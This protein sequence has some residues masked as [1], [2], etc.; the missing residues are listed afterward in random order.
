V[1]I[2]DNQGD[3]EVE[4]GTRNLKTSDHPV[5]QAHIELHLGFET[6]IGAPNAP[7]PLKKFNQEKQSEQKVDLFEKELG[8][9]L[10]KYSPEDIERAVDRQSVAFT[11]LIREDAFD[12]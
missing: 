6:W 12:G 1:I 7:A 3:Y 10:Q 2:I 9:Y 8:F 11:G 5:F 4:P